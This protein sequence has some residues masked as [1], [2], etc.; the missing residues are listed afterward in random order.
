L[1]LFFANQ[2]GHSFESKKRFLISYHHLPI[3]EVT[4]TSSTTAVKRTVYVYYAP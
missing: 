4:S 2:K 1:G 3:R